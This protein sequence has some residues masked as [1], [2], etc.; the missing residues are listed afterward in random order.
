MDM[1]TARARDL[2]KQAFAELPAADKSAQ[3]PGLIMAAIYQRVLNEVEARQYPVLSERVSI[4]P[5][6]KLL[7]A[8]KVW[9][10]P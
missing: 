8:L 10:R 1:Q 2:Y 5:I 7:L 3:R 6:T 4:S 9:L